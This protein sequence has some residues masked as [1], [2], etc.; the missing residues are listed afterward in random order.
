MCQEAHFFLFGKDN[1]ID[2]YQEYMKFAVSNL[3][4]FNESF[5]SF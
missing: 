3:T 1:S 5:Y 4:L 2:F